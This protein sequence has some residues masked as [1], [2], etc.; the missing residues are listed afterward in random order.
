MA[1]SRLLQNDNNFIP[2][3]SPDQLLIEYLALPLNRSPDTIICIDKKKE[4]MAARVKW[5]HTYHDFK[6]KK[7]KFFQSVAL[8]FE[9]CISLHGGTILILCYILFW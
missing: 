6:K 4:Q 2:E 9:L 8:P 7:K 1:K 3:I 5:K